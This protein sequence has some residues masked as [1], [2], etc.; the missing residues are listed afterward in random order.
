MA[1]GLLTNL[2][3]ALFVT[4]SG[5]G[6]IAVML[7]A[8]WLRDWLYHG[9]HRLFG[10]G[11]LPPLLRGDPGVITYSHEITAA[12]DAPRTSSSAWSSR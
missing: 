11:G 5:T 7:K 1:A 12:V 10:V 4:V 2:V 3:G 6:T 8:A 9:Q